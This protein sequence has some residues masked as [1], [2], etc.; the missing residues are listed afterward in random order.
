MVGNDPQTVADLQ[1]DCGGAKHAMFLG[2]ARH[3]DVGPAQ[4]MAVP[5]EPQQ[6]GRQNLGAC[7]DNRAVLWTRLS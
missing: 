7:I 2:Q 1:I 3:L 4:H 6:I 5:V